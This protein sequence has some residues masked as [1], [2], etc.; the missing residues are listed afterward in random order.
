MELFYSRDIADGGRTLDQEE[1]NHCIRV[2]RHA[3]GDVIHVVD[4]RGG[5]YECRI[6]DASPKAVGFTVLKVE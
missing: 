2:L 5:I 1:S 4:G 6:D 3:A